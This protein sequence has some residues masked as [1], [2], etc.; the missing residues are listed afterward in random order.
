MIANRA[1]VVG[2]LAL[3]LQWGGLHRADAATLS[4]GVPVDPQKAAEAPLECDFDPCVLRETAVSVLASATDALVRVTA[5]GPLVPLD[6]EEDETLGA[7]RLALADPEHEVRR[8]ACLALSEIG[9]AAAAAAPDLVRVAVQPPADVQAEALRALASIGPAD[10]VDLAMLNG[11]FETGALYVRLCAAAALASQA[12]DGERYL[13][14]LLSALHPHRKLSGRLAT[15]DLL[16]AVGS[17]AEP[18]LPAL[19]TCLRER[20]PVGA[21][22]AHAIAAMGCRPEDS[23]AA[24]LGAIGSPPPTEDAMAPEGI[25]A[26][27]CFPQQAEKIVPFLLGVLDAPDG[28]YHWAALG[29][30]GELGAGEA[31]GKERTLALIAA[32]DEF[33][34]AA[35]YDFLAATDAGCEF[36][37]SA[38][39]DAFPPSDDVV[40]EAAVRFL[41]SLTDSAPCRG[42]STALLCLASEDPGPGIRL[43]AV[44]ALGEAWRCEP[45][46]VAGALVA[47][48]DDARY[49]VIRAAV[50]SL[51]LMGPEAEPATAALAGLVE[52]YAGSAYEHWDV[53]YGLRPL[54]DLVRQ[55]LA[56]IQ[57]ATEFDPVQPG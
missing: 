56:R 50:A 32:D 40:R 57:G 4:T 27:G 35:V 7:L 26:L 38:K 36:L 45:E 6:G 48:L 20:G 3:L 25:L 28:P 31:L 1:V 21:M 39:R 8:A 44:E 19:F 5:V 42:E 52:T 12:Q 33:T 14:P 15:L 53:E 23:V 37:S 17:R 22:A 47:R 2:S 24:L 49:E 46:K 13:E 54:G 30:L 34:R 9:P 41:V 43:A 10:G 11:L 51:E 18:A 16:A 29:A 55:A